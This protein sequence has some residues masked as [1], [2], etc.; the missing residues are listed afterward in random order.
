MEKYSI[1]S[2]KLLLMQKTGKAVVTIETNG[3]V[4]LS[5]TGLEFVYDENA[6]KIEDNE[7]ESVRTNLALSKKLTFSSRNK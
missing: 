1:K 6:Q 2:Q 4:K 5:V 7:T 3:W